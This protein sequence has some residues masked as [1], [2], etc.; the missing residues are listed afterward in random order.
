MSPGSLLGDGPAGAGL[1]GWDPRD[2][3]RSPL[4]R[5]SGKEEMPWSLPPFRRCCRLCTCQKM[6][7]EQQQLKR[8]PPQA[9]THCPR[10]AVSSPRL[11]KEAAKRSSPER[12]LMG[13][14]AGHLSSC[15]Q[16]RPISRAGMRPQ[17][18]RPAQGCQQSHS[19]FWTWPGLRAQAPRRS[20]VTST[21]ESFGSG[22]ALELRFPDR[23]EN[24]EE[25]P[26]GPLGQ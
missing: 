3:S 13:V 6:V 8:P 19:R 26:M 9:G 11:A 2:H 25:K 14:G 16:A 4:L 17:A 24:T 20:Y 22:C 12:A 23:V 18:W 10:K 21:V 1:L 15:W 7:E 5:L